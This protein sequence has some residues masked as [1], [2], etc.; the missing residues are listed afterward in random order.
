MRIGVLFNCQ[1]RG[2]AESLRLLRPDDTVIYFAIPQISRSKEARAMAAAKLQNCDAIVASD[3]HYK[4]GPAAPERLR[5]TGIPMA[6]V[7]P[8]I[9]SGFHP[10]VCGPAAP[11]DEG[12]G[13]QFEGP[14]GMTHSRIA[15]AC[16]LGGLTPSECGA[17]YNRLIFKRLGYFDRYA[18]E[19]AL[20]LERYNAVSGVD[21]APLFH[22]W[23]A[24]GCFMHSDNHPKS[25]VLHD[26]AGIACK[27]LDL[28][29]EAG[30]GVTPQ[31]FLAHFPHHP[32]YP[33]IAAQFG[34][35]PMPYFR[36]PNGIKGDPIY[37]GLEE[38]LVLCY[39]AYEQI[40]RSALTAVD[41]M[42]GTMRTLGLTS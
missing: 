27:L 32:V 13:G 39:A 12:G 29:T 31:D 36:L 7:P 2:I 21:L 14:T 37:I 28:A 41:G 20:L 30:N 38:F 11:D 35:E 26:V 16:Y 19:H 6:T 34:I 18:E 42:T 33:E 25:Y 4:L 8:V 17:M 1:A 15:I 40:P 22:K 9:F 3:T 10:D 24:T 23:A 5:A